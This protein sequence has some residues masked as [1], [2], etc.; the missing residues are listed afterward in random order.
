[1]VDKLTETKYGYCPV[2]LKERDIAIPLHWDSEYETNAWDSDHMEDHCFEYAVCNCGYR[3]LLH[4]SSR[5]RDKEYSEYSQDS[6]GGCGGLLG[7]LAIMILLMMFMG[8]KC[9]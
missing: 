1:M 8:D 6:N 3:K 9:F 4:K 7:V 5:V 2:C